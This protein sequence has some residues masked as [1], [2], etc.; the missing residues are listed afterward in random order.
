MLNK[1]ATIGF[2][3]SCH[4]CTEAIFLS[5]KGVSS[6]QQGW[7]SSGEASEFFSEAVMVTFDE[8][9]ISLDLLIAIHLHTHSCTSSHSM[10]DKYRSAIYT[11]DD[12]QMSVAGEAL[13]HLQKEFPDPIITEVLNFHEFKLNKAEYLNYY[14]SN[15]EK[16]FCQNIVKPKLLELL[17]RFS[18]VVNDE[19]L[20]HLR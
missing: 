9:E 19:R 14:Y 2:G 12:L 11:F 3:G 1:T 16:P 6:V 15:P 17:N 10:R 18:K 20:Q 4:W 5:L 8:Q 13:E 7:I